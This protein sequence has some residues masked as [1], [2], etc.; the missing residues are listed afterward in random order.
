MLGKALEREKQ[1]NETT[2]RSLGLDTLWMRR[3]DT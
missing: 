2:V 1:T 3:E